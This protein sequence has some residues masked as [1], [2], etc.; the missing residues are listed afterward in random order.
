MDK[1]KIG[2][3]LV[4]LDKLLDRYVDTGPEA[5]NFNRYHAFTW[6]GTR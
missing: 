6:D 2:Q 3:L 5:P 4:K 1:P